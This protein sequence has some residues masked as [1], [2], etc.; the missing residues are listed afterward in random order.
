MSGCICLQYVVAT[1]NAC[2][3]FL[4]CNT[5]IEARGHQVRQTSVSDYAMSRYFSYEG[6]ALSARKVSAIY[7]IQ[8]IP[9]ESLCQ[10]YP[11]YSLAV[12]WT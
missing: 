3:N 2:I 4:L 11:T 7:I 1:E 8:S 5:E 9:S 12:K 10:Q 6:T